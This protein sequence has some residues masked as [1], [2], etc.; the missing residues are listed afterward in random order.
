LS[1]ET[2]T[3]SR[4]NLNI[5]SSIQRKVRQEPHLLR[6]AVIVFAVLLLSGFLS[7]ILPLDY[8]I[9]PV[10]LTVAFGAFIIFLRVPP[11]GIFAVIA[12]GLLVSF[13]LGTGTNSDINF[14]I[15][16]IPLLLGVWVVDMVVRKRRIHFV[17]SRPILPLLVL[18]VISII[19]FGIGQLPWFLYAKGAP[20]ISQV[21]GLFLIL[22]S[23][24]AFLL[25]ANLISD[26]LW[27]K[28]MTWFFLA[29]AGV[30]MIAA[31]VPA[32]GRIL[33]PLLP[34]GSRGS[35]FYVWLIAIAFSQVLINKKL[36]K[37]AR[38]ALIGLLII[39]FYV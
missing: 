7:F 13:E 30:Y 20:L 34:S 23:I 8:L 5:L 27:L 12:A 38:I 36:N 2:Q 31:S 37:Y 33:F 6:Q 9:F 22:M 15:I 10:G 4:I 21:A 25:V 26:I 32:I 19:S 14:V 39:T 16:L 28:R 35:L 18:A 11:I 24:G 17:S 29:V 1:H 3:E